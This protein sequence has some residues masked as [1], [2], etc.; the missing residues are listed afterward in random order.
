[1]KIYNYNLDGEYL[2]ESLGI[3]S[4]LEAGVF[5]IPSNATDREPPETGDHEAAVFENGEWTKKADY[6]GQDRWDKATGEKIS[7]AL[8]EIP[9]DSMT[10]LKP[11][12]PEHIWDEES[13]SWVI[14]LD[15]LKKEKIE[16][17]RLAWRSEID[18]VGMPV[19]GEDYRVDFD[20]EDALIWEN[21]LDISTVDPV[22]IRA[23]DNT[24]HIMT[25]E[26]ALT[27]PPLQKQHYAQVLQ[28]KWSLQKQ[29][30]EAETIE[31]I[32]A[33]GWN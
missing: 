5:L 30:S 1:M 14:P 6:R 17:I 28:K 13:N 16:E 8:G 27:I 11:P 3:E 19:P 24:M 12:S 20:V 22:E 15:I 25:R 18:D 7:L 26:V 21:G 29:A 10:D 9:N 33:I 4:P 23:K 31:N 2:G 32:Q